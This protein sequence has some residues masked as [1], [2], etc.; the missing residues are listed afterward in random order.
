MDNSTK[1]HNV[2]IGDR[3]RV[4]KHGQ[5]VVVDLYDVISRTT[6]E[7]VRSICIAKGEGLATNEFEVPFSTVVRNRITDVA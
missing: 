6:G 5:A 7:C 4:G 3:F 2:S 1:I